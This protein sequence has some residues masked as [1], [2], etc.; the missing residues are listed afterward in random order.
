MI[1]DG[2][3]GDYFAVKEIGRKGKRSHER[4]KE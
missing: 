1:V 4:E 3:A 2:D